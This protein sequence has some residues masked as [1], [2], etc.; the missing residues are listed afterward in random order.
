MLS[1]CKF[2]RREK[3][4]R[5]DIISVISLIACV[6]VFVVSG[7]AFYAAKNVCE[8]RTWL[9]CYLSYVVFFSA[10][11]FLSI[12]YEAMGHVRVGIALRIIFL[13]AVLIFLM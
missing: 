6:L 8:I 2:L 11:F 4:R 10:A 1:I 5:I 12:I 7:K 13:I 9:F 3:I